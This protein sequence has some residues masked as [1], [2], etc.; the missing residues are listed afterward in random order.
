MAN[1][2]KGS[3]DQGVMKRE[4]AGKGS[5]GAGGVSASGTAP[6]ADE[7]ELGSEDDLRVEDVM[8]E[9]VATLTPLCNAKKA[10][11]LMRDRDVGF[12]PVVAE[13][14]RVVGV[15]TDRD[16]VLGVLASDRPASTPAKDVMTPDPVTC[17]V[18]DDLQECERLMSEN[19]INRMVVLGEDG[20]LAGVVSLADLALVETDHAVGDLVA[21][22][23]LGDGDAR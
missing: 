20:K 17:T 19:Q 8:T 2:N 14:G 15:V 18:G 7:L 3:V 9:D 23:R 12:L 21:D 22:V 6:E 4:T 10:A 11:V 13:D 16:L 1:Q 5:L